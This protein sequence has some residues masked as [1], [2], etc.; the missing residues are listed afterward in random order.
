[1]QPISENTPVA[2][3]NHYGA[4]KAAVENIAMAYYNDYGLPLTIVRPFNHIGRGQNPKF[5]VP[6][7][8]QAFGNKEDSLE[9][10]NID[11]ARDFVDVRDVI[12]AYINLLEKFQAGECFNICSG[13]N[14]TIREIISDLEKVTGHTMEIKKNEEFVRKNEIESFLGDF[15]KLNKAVDWNPRFSL[16]DT[17]SWILSDNR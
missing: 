12:T 4:S 13:K 5:V 8:I 9:L 16:T 11:V 17:L 3:V 7:I 2:P 14:I 6:K 15:S 1:M 10:G